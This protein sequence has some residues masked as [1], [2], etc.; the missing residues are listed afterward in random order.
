MKK[1]SGPKRLQLNRETLSNLDLQ[2]TAGGLLS[3][4]YDCDWKGE[5]KAFSNCDYCGRSLD[6]V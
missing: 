4:I 3:W 2:K 5:S 6:C 1:K